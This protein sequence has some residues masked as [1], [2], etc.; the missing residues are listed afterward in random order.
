MEFAAKGGQQADDYDVIV[1]GADVRGHPDAALHAVEKGLKTAMIG[2]TLVNRGRVP[3]K[4]L[5]VVSGRMRELPDAH[6]LKA[7]CI[8]VDAATYDRQHF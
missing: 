5:L 2:G 3:S 6:H 8:Q 4:V 7:S 1:I